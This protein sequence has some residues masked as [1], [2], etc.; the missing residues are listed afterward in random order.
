MSEG[1]IASDAWGNVEHSKEL[2]QYL[3]RA[4]MDTKIRSIKQKSFYKL[5]NNRKDPVVLL[6]CGC[7]NGLDVLALAC[8][9]PNGSRI[10]GIDTNA[11]FIKIAND[12][13]EEFRKS[14]KSVEISFAVGNAAS[15]SEFPDNNFDCV[16]ADRVILHIPNPGNALSEM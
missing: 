9:V 15:M 2:D 6:D 13:L 1:K 5:L 16:R 12:N 8:I 11:Q 10:Y 14:N 7:G 3:T 4:A